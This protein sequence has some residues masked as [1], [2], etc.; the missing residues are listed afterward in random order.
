MRDGD[1]L[2]AALVAGIVGVLLG[3]ALMVL[4]PDSFKATVERY[5]D[6][7]RSKA[8]SVIQSTPSPAPTVL[9][10]PVPTATP[11][12]LSCIAV[13]QR[14]LR[15][16]VP[17]SASDQQRWQAAEIRCRSQPPIAGRDAFQ[18]L[19]MARRLAA[20][21]DEA[22]RC[23][24][25]AF[26]LPGGEAY[27]AEAPHALMS[28]DTEWS[29]VYRRRFEAMDQERQH[30]QDQADALVRE[31]CRSRYDESECVSITDDESGEQHLCPLSLGDP[32][33]TGSQK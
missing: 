10:S 29:D 14:R 23:W 11:A 32:T 25:L 33:S 7:L 27:L 28:G 20:A 17:R 22:D 21:S 18:L 30:L 13:P 12:A 19:N 24:S 16:P 6:N 9:P 4:A 1:P 8:Q 3:A 15:T 26:A 31:L 2:V 5:A